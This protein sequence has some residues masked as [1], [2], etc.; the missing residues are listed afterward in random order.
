M[1]RLLW[2]ASAEAR[3]RIPARIT[4]STPDNVEIRVHTPL[5]ASLHAFLSGTSRRLLDELSETEAP[6][7]SYLAPGLARD[8][9]AAASFYVHGPKALRRLR[10]RHRQPPG[11]L[12]RSR[13]EALL[14]AEAHEAIGEF[15][16]PPRR[17]P[18]EKNL[19]RRAHPWARPET[20]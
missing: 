16:L 7:E 2:A 19:G 18:T 10:L 11:A 6:S 9:E 17:D 13:I 1:L 15:Q 14:A 4:R 5:R 8:R 20:L 12:S 3:D